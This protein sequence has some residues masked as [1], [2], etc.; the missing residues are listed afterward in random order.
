MP[1]NPLAHGPNNPYTTL[2]KSSKQCLEWLG[3]SSP[4]QTLAKQLQA[5][6]AADASAEEDIAGIGGW[7]VLLASGLVCR[8]LEHA[9]SPLGLAQHGVTLRVS[10]TSTLL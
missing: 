6:A 4:I 3:S 7:T 5:L 8:N 9:R 1:A 2:S 10:T